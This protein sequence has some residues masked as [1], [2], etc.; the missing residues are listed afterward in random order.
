LLSW[1]IVLTRTVKKRVS[2]FD[3]RFSE[4]WRYCFCEGQAGICGREVTA[5]VDE[6]LVGWLVV[7]KGRKVEE[8]RCLSS[9]RRGGCGC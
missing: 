8:R 3:G 7:V 1:W 4:C 2:R 5:G 9:A 6:C